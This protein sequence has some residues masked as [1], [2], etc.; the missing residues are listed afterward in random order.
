MRT[1]PADAL[2]GLADR[3]AVVV[4]ELETRRVAREAKGDAVVVS[5]DDRRRKR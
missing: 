5:L 3:M 1:A 2:A 4:R